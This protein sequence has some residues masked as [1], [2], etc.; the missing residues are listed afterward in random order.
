MSYPRDSRF[1]SASEPD[2]WCW[3]QGITMR[4][5]PFTLW[6]GISVVFIV[7]AVSDMVFGHSTARQ[8]LA[9][10]ALALVWPVALLSSSGRA[11]LLNAGR[12]L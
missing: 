4:Y 1:D 3:Q 11:L 5:L 8:L 7:Y 9:R 10:M 2:R 6:V 12:G